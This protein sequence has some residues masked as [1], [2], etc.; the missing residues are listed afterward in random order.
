VPDLFGKPQSSAQTILA[1]SGL[2]VGTVT[3]GYHDTVIPGNVMGQSPAAGT[4]APQGSAVALVICTGPAPVTLPPDPATVAPPVDPTVATSVHAATRF[5]YTG[6]API[7][8]GVAEGTI[9]LKRAAVLR[10]RVLTRDNTPLSGVTITILNHPEFGRTISRE[11]G[12]FDLAVNGGGY[13]TVEYVRGGY[14]PVHRQAN[15]PWQDY[16]VLPDVVMIAYDNQVTSVDLASSAPM[17]VARGNVVTDSDGTRQATLLF[18]EGIQATMMLPDGSTRSLGSLNIRATEFTVGVNGPNAMPAPLPPSSGYTYCV[19]LS[20]DEA[21]AAGADSVVFDKPLAHYVENFL[22]LPVGVLVPA[23]YYDR[24]QGVWV[25]SKNGRVVRIIGVT[26][27]KADLDTD[28]DGAIDNATLLADLGI[29]DAEREKLASLYSPNTS[30]WRLPISHFSPWDGNYPYGVPPDAESPN[31]GPVVPPNSGSPP[32]GVCEVF[33][34]IIECQGQV[35]GESASIAGTPYSLNYRSNRV[36]GRRDAYTVDIPLSGSIIPASLLRIELEIHVAGKR[37][38]QSFPPVSNQRTSFTWDGKDS[39]GRIVQGEQ[40]IL[41]RVGF[42]Y[43]VVY[44]VPALVEKSFALFGSAVIEGSRGRSDVIA[45]QEWKGSVGTWDALTQGIGGWTLDIQHYYDPNKK[46]LYLGDGTTR[47]ASDMSKV[48]V[49]IQTP[50]YPNWPYGVTTTPDGDIFYS[51]NWNHQVFRVKPD[52]SGTRVA[53]TEVTQWCGYSGC[54]FGYNGDG[55]LA[56]EALLNFPTGIA[57]DHNGNIYIADRN[58]QRIRKVSPNGLI[59]TVAGTGEAGYNG[60][61][62]LA[63]QAKITSPY[64]VA[65][66][67]DGSLYFSEEGGNRIR[68]VGTDGFI[69]TVAGTGGGGFNGDNIKATQATLNYPRGIAFGPNGNLYVADVRNMRIRRVSPDGIISTV[70]GGSYDSRDGIPAIMAF[71]NYPTDVSVGRDGTLFITDQQNHKVRQVRPD[72]I[73][74]TIAGSGVY[75]FSGDGG[76]ASDARLGSPGE[77]DL[78]PDGALYIADITNGKIRMVRSVIP[79]ISMGEMMISSEAGDQLYIFDDKGRHLKTINSLSGVLVYRFTYDLSG[80]LSQVID[81]DNNVTQIERDVDGNLIA[82][83]APGGQRTTISMDAYGYLASLSNPAGDNIQLTYSAD[84]NGLLEVLS[85]QRGLPHLFAYDS[86][87]RLVRDD[88]PGG[89]YKTLTRIDNGDGNGYSV[90]VST[91]LGRTT[92]YGVFPRAAGGTD[93]V[94]TFPGGGSSLTRIGTDGTS[95][96]WSADNTVTEVV[97]GPDPRFGMQA[98]IRSSSTVSTPAG[99]VSVTASERTTILAD[100]GNA[101]S[102]L[103]QTDT[104]TV[105][106]RIYT[107]TYDNATRQTTSTTPAGRTSISTVDEKGRVVSVQSNLSVLPTVFS[108]DSYGRIYRTGQGIDLWTYLYDEKHRLWKKSD[109]LDNTTEYGYDAADRMNMLKLPSGRTY[110]FS[111]DRAGNRTQVVMPSGAVHGLGYSPVNL[112]NAYTPP[113]NPSYYHSYS[114]DREWT[115]TELPGGRTIEASYDNAER[116]LTVSYPEATIEYAYN[117]G[118]ERIFSLTRRDL[119]DN[120]TQTLFYD[121]DG[122]LTTGISFSGAAN[123]EYRFT[124]DNNFWITGMS[125]DSVGRPLSRDEDGLLS[126][127]GP[128]TISRNG[129]SG[130]PDS[131]TDMTPRTCG[132]DGSGQPVP[133][134]AGTM[135]QT[136]GFD[137]FGRMNRRTQTVGGTAIYEEHLFRDPAGK[138]TRKTETVGGTSREYEYNYDAD[139]QLIEVKKDGALVERYGYDNNANRTSTLVTTA[140]YDSQ[141]RLIEQGGISYAFDADGF[142]S[143]R[144]T[145]QFAYSSR[146]ELLAATVPGQTVTYQYDGTNRRVARTDASGTTQYL[147]GTLFNP[148]QMTASRTSPDDVVTTYY[149]DEAG[150]LLSFERNEQRYY[151]GSDHLGTPKVITDNVGNIVRQMEY[152]AWGVKTGDTNPSFHLPVGFAGGIPDETTGL[153]RFGFR[154]YEPGTGRWAAKDP[155]FFKGGQA[156]LYGYV[157]GDPINRTDPAGMSGCTPGVEA[158]CRR[159][160]E[161]R[162]ETYEDCTPI[163]DGFL[164]ACTGINAGICHCVKKRDRSEECYEKCKH[165]LPSPSGDLQASEYRKCYR[166]CMGTL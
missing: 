42:A 54:N 72:G 148:F 91:A 86:L 57:V 82:F 4:S 68:R 131:V 163:L 111:F 30:F 137:P 138:I 55:I 73:I 15:V 80:K 47:N 146:G 132:T 44:T 130:A 151:V 45:W 127:E 59:T 133:C 28:G 160:C 49:S 31:G 122:A 25:P 134:V 142:L 13:L 40:P 109:P 116:L 92:N 157:G 117:D 85:D 34:S 166:E 9:E 46:K 87:G 19:D 156:N 115:R 8:T 20:A 81:V 50:S 35:L 16:V 90:D 33:G 113:D 70:A 158:D 95:K 2:V 10:G 108:Y 41:V 143:L 64:G 96:S 51:D 145:N 140:T 123:G 75:G 150:A 159:K 104:T 58:N 118:T 147:Y 126:G 161:A 139:G 119:L 74:T 27:G 105:N 71:L 7:Q 83:V 67:P 77:L 164:E 165:L 155:I 106:G 98:P 149:Y 79:W 89:G 102:L 48:I 128:F 152:D 53:G 141:D 76:P 69:S 22:N 78:G 62:I 88:D 120:T 101:I 5:L 17:Q 65:S 38:T 3:S 1:G 37:Y 121:Y 153:V 29:D 107:T 36:P 112:D 144:G 61:E 18:P 110:R 52:G 97:T 6:D 135:L 154:D 100:P 114:L 11:D 136:Y 125:F 66:G 99:L 26:G 24:K 94:N 14:L 39:F 21:V 43:P 63:T 162:G 84:G 12:M 124:Y 60:D 129:P 32:G 56:V 93:L 103:S 23:G